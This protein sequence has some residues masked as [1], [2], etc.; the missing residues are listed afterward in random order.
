MYPCVVL[1]SFS[2]LIFMISV[3]LL[4]DTI[5]AAVTPI[6][7]LNVHPI[8]VHVSGYTVAFLSGQCI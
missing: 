4:L 2:F 5:S 8:A 3:N 1:N 7:G 6:F